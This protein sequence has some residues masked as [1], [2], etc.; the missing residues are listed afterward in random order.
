LARKYSTEK[1]MTSPKQPSMKPTKQ[2]LKKESYNTSKKIKNLKTPKSNNGNKIKYEI[3]GV[4][5]ILISVLL[6]LSL[7]VINKGI[8]GE[9][10]SKTQLGIFGMSAYFFPLLLIF[11][12][13][14]LILGKD[15][16]GINVRYFGYVLLFISFSAALYLG[17]KSAFPFN[18]ADF[19]VGINKF[20]E[21]AWF[22]GTDSI[23]G[24][25]I[26]SFL[27]GSLFYCFGIAG[28]IVLV[29]FLVLI[30]I[31]MIFKVSFS[32]LLIK[33]KQVFDKIIFS[34]EEASINMKNRRIQE[35]EIAEKTKENNKDSNKD[36]NKDNNKENQESIKNLNNNTGIGRFD[37]S[38]EEHQA[39]ILLSNLERV[40]P[41]DKVDISFRKNNIV[42][43]VKDFGD[44]L[45]NNEPPLEFDRNEKIENLLGKTVGEYKSGANNQLNN[46]N[47]INH[48]NTF[49]H[50]NTIDN[51]NAMD[52]ENAFSAK[53][54]YTPSFIDEK[55]KGSNVQIDKTV[56][57]LNLPHGIDAV[58]LDCKYKLPSF[59][60]L[61]KAGKTNSSLSDMEVKTN[62]KILQETLDNFGVSATI[63]D[64][65]VGPSITRYELQLAP[66][67]KVSKISSL[68]EDI[69][70][71][72][73]SPGIRIAPI[74]GKAAIGIEVPNKIVSNVYLRDVLES[75]EF[76]HSK[77]KLTIALGKDV[78]GANIIGD[79]S[80][81]PHL[82]IAG[83]TGSGKS[84]CVN[85]LIA[86]IL[87]KATPDEVKL[88]MIDP[89]V[90]ELSIYKEIPH[91]LV[92]VVT[93]PKKAAGALNWAVQ[94]M[95]ERY[96][97]FA[98]ASVRDITGFNASEK[99][100]HIKLPHIVVLIDEL[101]DLMMVAPGDVEDSICRLAQMA[102]AAGIHLVIATQRPSVDVITGL[103]KANVPSRISFAVSSSIDSRTILDEGGAE[104][105]LGKG[106]MLFYPV[107]FPKPMR[108]Q[109]AFVSEKE[110][111]KLVDF[112][113]NQVKPEY[114]EDIIKE[115]EET[116]DSPD[117]I[118][119]TDVLLTEAMGIVVDTGQASITLL[120]R[121]LK[122]GYN[123]AARLIDQ[124]EERR[125]IGGYEGSKPRKVLVS[126]DQ[127]DEWAMENEK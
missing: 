12:G 21:N 54:F 34:F 22:L 90:V 65:S 94:E 110:I 14:A 115:L 5:L 74:P 6:G 75:H 46:N 126:R 71:S 28:S 117:I 105:L 3:I 72:L 78:A 47:M 61:N 102:R 104:K 107:G 112:V 119:D 15:K 99:V 108:V 77:S 122:I 52:Y 42:T 123:R 26:G 98:G 24:G 32:S 19:N 89:K 49:D 31:L 37:L 66:G 16:I 2:P 63:L 84:V 1:K 4:L 95:T 106:D 43:F 76:Q 103:I 41:N 45:F 38:E 82:L 30:S 86:S 51:E 48:R 9:Y 36:K 11:P 57:P 101:A 10:F 68:S 80:K 20:L 83:S 40:K 81:M 100:E 85:T 23:G 33:V 17:S 56:I 118:E 111:E 73:A 50:K 29:L 67:V 53:S 125:I 114:N 92:P 91:L 120:Q 27:G 58:D 124:M 116:V 70:L 44:N 97:L 25:V 62:A 64:A 88:I 60:L 7:F 55:S 69:S 121:R 35:K 59:D 8:I 87:Y 93:D 13:L 18:E 96:K 79:L 127:I 39:E 109:G 113:K